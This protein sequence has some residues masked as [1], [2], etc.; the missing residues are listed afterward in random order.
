MDKS[1]D[2]LSI[3]SI[4]TFLLFS[5]AAIKILLLGEHY[6]VGLSGYLNFANLLVFTFDTLRNLLY[7]IL[8]VLIYILR[9]D[10]IHEQVQRLLMKIRLGIPLNPNL[11]A[12]VLWALVVLSA[13]ITGCWYK[14]DFLPGASMYVK[15][16]CEAGVFCGWLLA[17]NW[18][19][20]DLR[21]LKFCLLISFLVMY[22]KLDFKS[23]M[24][25]VPEWKSKIHGKIVLKYLNIK[26]STIC[27]DSVTYPI[28]NTTDYLFIYNDTTK[29]TSVFPVVNILSFTSS[30]S[31]S[32][33]QACKNDSC[34][35][36]RRSDLTSV[37]RRVDSTS[38]TRKTDSAK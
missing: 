16:I 38:I 10:W 21:L 23:S 34:C 6:D 22:I 29:L 7:F 8:P 35:K 25:M 36:N 37:N 20:I 2:N 17:K 11:K 13:I 27:L 1:K 28:F 14:H 24:N 32:S 26:D 30:E 9:K 31:N 19:L 3:V 15:Y 33:W 12:S 4:V 18:K 5:I